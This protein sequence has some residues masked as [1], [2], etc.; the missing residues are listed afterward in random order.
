MCG[1]AAVFDLDQSPVP[2]DPSLV[3]A[4]RDRLTHR[5]PDDSGLWEGERACIGHRR[6]SVID[7]SPLGHQP[8][9]SPD[10]RYVLA[11]NGELYND[12]D[13]RAEL[14]SMGV[15]FRTACDSETILHAL[16]TWG[17]DAIDKLR[18]MYAFVFYD[19]QEHQLTLARDPLGVKPLYYSTIDHDGENRFAVASEIPA[20]LE[21]PGIDR[22]PDPIT[23]SAYLSTIRTT[24]GSRTMFSSIHTLEPGDWIRIHFKDPQHPIARNWWLH[25][26]QV[27][28]QGVRQ[29]IE[30]SLHRHLRT[31][32]PMCALLSGG[33]DSA[34]TASLAMRS[35]GELNTFCAGARTEGFDDDFVFAREMAAH[36]ST[37]HHEV[38]V[39][40]EHFIEQL[41]TLINAMG[42]PVSTPNEIAIHEVARALRS[43]GHIV[44]ISGEGADELFGGYVPIMDQCVQHVAGLEDPAVD[45]EGGAFHLRANAWISSELKPCVLNPIRLAEAQND[46]CLRHYY[47]DTFCSIHDRS[48]KDSP[49]QAH[50]Q[51][52]RR[53]NL[54]NLLQRLD[55]ATM[56]AGVEGRTPYADIEV[57]MSAQHLQMDRKYQYHETDPKTKIALREAFAAE[58]PHRILQR[59]KASFPLPFQQWMDPFRDFLFKSPFA[60]QY[61]TAQAVGLV[62]AN[63][64]KYWHMAWPM[65]S[66][67]LWGHAWVLDEPCDPQQFAHAGLAC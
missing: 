15:E 18:G 35:L 24:L 47:N 25:A 61:F 30:D 49:L 12:H 56:L 4:M 51:F 13:L 31:D 19:T 28:T 8:M 66:L 58:I 43:Q 7:P 62:A 46:E 16:I 57:A 42:N 3:A 53:M 23:L 22:R 45:T 44:A 34:I 2:I 26:N 67:T 6:L 17:D 11:Y 36:L 39:T 64:M 60:R 48:P 20:L 9:C 21:H 32:V 41:P 38:V 29:T 55:T 65:I 27:P 59:P 37:N 33:L 54:P 63:P 40:Q 52:Q 14:G 1:I 5:G 10:G 50:L